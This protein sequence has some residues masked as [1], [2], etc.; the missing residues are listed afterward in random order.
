MNKIKT[1]NYTKML[2]IATLLILT[3]AAWFYASHAYAQ[4]T[5]TDIKSL[6]STVTGQFQS[7]IK[8][9]FAVAYLAGFAFVIASIFK[10]KQHKDNPTQIPMGTPI[11]MLAIGIA[12]IFLPNIIAPAGASIF[13]QGATQ[14]GYTGKGAETTTEE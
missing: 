3:A 11:A 8:L 12:L 2:K 13:G 7:V 5:V 4:G 1:I 10:F 6:H 14:S 9:M